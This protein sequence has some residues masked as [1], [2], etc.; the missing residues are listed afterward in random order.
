MRI[1]ENRECLPQQINDAS[2][3]GGEVGTTVGHCEW[4]DRVVCEPK[5]CPYE[6]MVMIPNH[7]K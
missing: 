5:S 4:T 2:M 3:D 7:F 6:H 1:S